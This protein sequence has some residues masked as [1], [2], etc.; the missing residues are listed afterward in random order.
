M[1][2]AS[3]T[4]WSVICTVLMIWCVFSAIRLAYRVIR[5]RK[6]LRALRKDNE[7][8]VR[9]I[10][11]QYQA[12]AYLITCALELFGV[13]FFAIMFLR[14][15]PLSGWTAAHALTEQYASDKPTA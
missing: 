6:M 4:M 11:M 8:V 12:A 15:L 3:F 7:T 10:S 13:I 9:G 14:A 2:T 5:S 1:T